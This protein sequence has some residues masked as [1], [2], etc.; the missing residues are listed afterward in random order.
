LSLCLDPD[1]RSA[2]SKIADRVVERVGSSSRRS[3]GEG[4]GGGGEDPVAGE[5]G[6]EGGGETAGANEVFPEASESGNLNPKLQRF[7]TASR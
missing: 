5:A 1:V 7:S 4:E 3:G 6:T 2:A